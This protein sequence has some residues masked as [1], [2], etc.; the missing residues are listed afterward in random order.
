[1]FDKL[2]KSTKAMSWIALLTFVVIVLFVV[3]Q[4]RNKNA[5]GFVKPNVTA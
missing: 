3:D 1:M 5:F 4:Y 2:F